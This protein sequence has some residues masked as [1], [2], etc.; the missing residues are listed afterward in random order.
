MHAAGRQDLADDP[1]LGDNQGRVDHE[2]LID[3]AL[4]EWTSK[5]S[6]AELFDALV[7][8]DVPCGPVYSI[9]DIVKDPHYQARQVWEEVQFGGAGEKVKIPAVLP[10]FSKTPGRTNWIGPKLGAHNDEIYKDWLKLEDEEI[11]ALKQHGVI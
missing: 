6:Y 8:A 1:R 4:Q 10:K 5:H 3:S 9:A 7:E 11:S 2:Q